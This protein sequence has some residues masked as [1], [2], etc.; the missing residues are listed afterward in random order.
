MASID[1]LTIA[2][3]EDAT[4]QTRLVRAVLDLAGAR[5]VEDIV[6][7]VRSA[8]R[9]IAHA[10]GATFVLRDNGRCYYVDEDAIAPLWR[11]LRFPM[12]DC[13][14][15]WAMLRAQQM[16]IPDIYTDRRIPQDA[17]RPTFVRSLAMTPIRTADPLGAI[18]VY[19]AEEHE[20]TPAECALLQALADS[21]ALAMEN[22]RVLAEIEERRASAAR[23][24]DEW[25]QACLE[26]TRELLDDTSRNPLASIAEQ[27][28]VL[29]AADSAH[30][31]LFD[32]KRSEVILAVAAGAD[33]V[34]GRNQRFPLS[35]T[36]SGIV[37][38]TGQPLLVED[39]RAQP[40]GAVTRS[41]VGHPI[42]PVMVVPLIARGRTRGT[43]VMTRA[44]GAPTFDQVDVDQASAF[45][46]HAAIALEFADARATKQELALREERDRIAADLHD[47]A[48]QRLFA[49]GMSLQGLLH[50]VGAGP[51]TE[52]LERS[53]TEIDRTIGGIRNAIYR[54]RTLGP[55]TTGLRDRVLEVLAEVGPL[56]VDP[57][58]VS[59]AGPLDILVNQELLDDV[60]AVLR[61]SL[62][63]V[64][65]HAS[66]THTQV[67]LTAD[68]DGTRLVVT[69]TDDGVGIGT[70][71][72]SS[73]TAN[74]TARAQR[75]GGECSIV[76]PAAGGR[77]TRISWTVPID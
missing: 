47:D 75:R 1:V 55:V 18:G 73:G 57:P 13:I 8:A 48:I 43:L 19:W 26:I 52:R 65:R 76:S 29:S 60:A 38:G 6:R 36:Y 69:V 23:K 17:Y 58:S 41:M 33:V 62:T 10:D 49:A 34:A 15:G 54:I 37:I 72:R 44:V 22:V 66:A 31:A 27:A 68:P 45:A 42:G 70:P 50:V 12:E 7:I 4:A 53:I 67:E 2:G 32:Q 59:F 46:N 61:E 63:N 21:T 51:Q 28:R 3:A 39:A 71:T 74:L 11:G 20:A 64:A 35:E 25:L 56:F 14:S 30:V 5:G 16:V 9:Q 40:R 24:R 77:G